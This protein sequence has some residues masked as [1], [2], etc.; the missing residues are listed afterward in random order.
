MNL[1]GIFPL[2][3]VVETNGIRVNR[4]DD[5]L[6]SDQVDSAL[7][8]YTSKDWGNLCEEDAEMNNEP[9][10]TIMGVYDTSKGEI[11][12]ITEWDKSVTTILFP[13]EY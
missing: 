6:F 10:G 9:E 12:I 11:W 5:P 3:K 1:F 2:G 7:F 13:D 8:R 4:Q